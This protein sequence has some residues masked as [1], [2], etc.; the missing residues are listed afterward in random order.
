MR[1]VGGGG[2]LGRLLLRQPFEPAAGFPDLSANVF[3]L[4]VGQRLGTGIP[5]P[6]IEDSED[7]PVDEISDPGR[8]HEVRGEAVIDRPPIVGRGSAHQELPPGVTS[9][10]R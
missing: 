10:I 9:R 8:G 1:S 3:A 5:G 7:I 6:I 2:R 4:F